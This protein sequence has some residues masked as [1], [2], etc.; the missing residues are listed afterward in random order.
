LQIV[1]FNFPTTLIRDSCQYLFF[2]WPPIADGR[3][4]SGSVR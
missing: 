1:S 3:K 4:A 2:R